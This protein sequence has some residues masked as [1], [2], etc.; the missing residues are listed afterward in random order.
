[1]VFAGAGFSTGTAEAKD[2][3]EGLIAWLSARRVQIEAARDAHLARAQLLFA[4]GQ[5][6]DRL[7]A[8]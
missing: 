6:R 7:G 4:V 8:P 1:M 2:V 5:D 3:L